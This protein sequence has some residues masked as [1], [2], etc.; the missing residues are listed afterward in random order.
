[1]PDRCVEPAAH[2]T[3]V[4]PRV[5]PTARFARELGEM[6]ENQRAHHV[7][8]YTGDVHQTLAHFNERPTY[9]VRKLVVDIVHGDAKPT[10]ES[11]HRAAPGHRTPGE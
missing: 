4:A 2:T 7:D 8:R 1:M 6:S 10:S 5:T 3:G 11:R 9:E